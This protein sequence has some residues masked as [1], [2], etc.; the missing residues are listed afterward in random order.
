MGAP[1]SRYPFARLAWSLA[2]LAAGLE[3]I[4]RA[5]AEEPP[6]PANVLLD[7][8]AEDFD[9]TFEGF[10]KT[11][12][13]EGIRLADPVNGWGG[14]AK[15]FAASDQS[16]WA[17]A[18]PVLELTLEPANELDTLTF[19]VIDS[20]G[21][22]G[23][24]LLLISGAMP[25]VRQ[26]IAAR[27]PL[28]TPPQEIGGPLD[29]TQLNRW[30]LL[31][32]WDS[33]MKPDVTIHRVTLDPSIAP[34]PPYEGQSP[35]AAWRGQAAS[36]IDQ[37]RKG[38]IR[39][40]VRDAAG[41]P[42]RNARV[43]IEMT[44]SEF[45]WGTAVDAA[46]L[47][48]DSPYAE[49][50]R[51]RLKALFNRVTIENNLKW[52]P[53]EGEWSARYGRA[54]G[55]AALDWLKQNGL[56]A[57]GHNLIWPGEE[58]LPRRFGPLLASLDG[59]PSSSSQLRDE[60][61][62]RIADAM[63]ATRGM[64]DSWDV[65]NEPRN[66]DDLLRALPEGEDA[67]ADWLNQARLQDADAAL[68]INE[69]EIVASG[70]GVGTN[71]V[72]RLLS[73]IDRVQAAGAPLDGVGVQCHFHGGNLSGPET[74]WAI[75]DAIASRGVQVHASEFEF[76]TTDET[77]QAQFTDD[78]LTA[79]FAHPAVASVTFWG[80][81]EQRHW[82]P[83][84]AMFRA[85]GTAKPA[86]QV[87][88]Q[89]VLGDWRTSIN[90]TVTRP[91]GWV[92]TTRVF[93]GGYWVSSVFAEASAS[94]SP[95]V[96]EDRVTVEFALPI[97]LGDYDRNGRI[98]FADLQL[99]RQQ[100]GQQAPPGSGADGDGDGVVTNRDGKLWRAAREAFVQRWQNPPAAGDYN[101]DGQINAADR[102]VCEQTQGMTVR[103]GMYADGDGDGV[104]GPG[105][106]A[107]IDALLAGGE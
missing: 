106:L 52:P 10:T 15:Q 103:R 51:Q 97:L 23:K 95:E 43:D 92:S 79:A 66:D 90:T 33:T 55:L 76:N 36:Q 49:A 9:W 18:T 102:Q 45:Q 1:L 13:A 40:R 22:R 30:Q 100:R 75:F 38:P 81:D 59:E 57:R 48:E 5:A 89:R 58:E 88:Q 86:G 21:N 60:V 14:A 8:T 47:V 31:G 83:P 84:A 74:V 4:D 7:G 70:G 77:L 63:Q 71:R 20:A 65:V 98:E 42:V 96:G 61:A 104:V 82:R 107:V 68:L 67:I 80:F 37:H 64:V 99:Q 44:R 85:D 28:A 35:T 54:T 26:T 69:N 73:L 24:W 12:E 25:G 41:R 93:R 53:W 27:A 72:A 105:D 39:V 2:F 78:F 87:Y 34:Q 16:A 101:A 6:P 91:D 17:A 19:E 3:P 32:E 62:E 46:T 29:L 50:Y 56:P 94:M 11:S